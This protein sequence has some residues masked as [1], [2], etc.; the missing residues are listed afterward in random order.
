MKLWRG[1]REPWRTIVP[2]VLTKCRIQNQKQIKVLSTRV[3]G[4]FRAPNLLP[5]GATQN[6]WD[7]VISWDWQHFVQIY[8]MRSSKSDSALWRPN[9][10]APNETTLGRRSAL[11]GRRQILPRSVPIVTPGSASEEGKLVWEAV[12]PQS[13]MTFHGSISVQFHPQINGN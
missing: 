5:Q 10:R 12:A 11:W 13:K 3:S 2:W 6:I 7:A 1:N 4:C 8:T 9:T